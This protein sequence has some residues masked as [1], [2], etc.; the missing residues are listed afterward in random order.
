M[1]KSKNTKNRSKKTD[2]VVV[3]EFKNPSETLL[4]KIVIWTLLIGFVG[5]IFLGAIMALSGA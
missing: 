3:K 5:L 2:Q 4:G 1:A